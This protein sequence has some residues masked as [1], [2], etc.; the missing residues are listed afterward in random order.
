MSSLN[1]RDCLRKALALAAVGGAGGLSSRL[2]LAGSGSGDARLVVVILRGALD[3]LALLPPVGDADYAAARGDQALSLTAGEHA[4]IPLTGPFA[5]HPAMGFL[6]ERWQAR[7][8]VALHAVASPYRERSHFD[9]QDVLETGYA[10]PHAVQSGWLNRALPAV[11]KAGRR[12]TAVALGPNVPLILRGSS[13]VAAWSPSRLPMLDED[14]L[15][16][17]AELYAPDTLLSGRLADALATEDMVS[18]AMTA[19]ANAGAQL[20]QTVQAA[21]GFLV[22]EDGPRVAVFDTSG[23]DTHANEGAAQGALAQ[24]LGVL[25]QGLRSLCTSLGDVWQHTAVVVVTEFGRTVA[26]NG[27]RGTDHGTGAAALLV[28]GGVQGGRVIA[29]W[30]GLSAKALYAGRDLQPTLD[31]RSVFKSLLRDHLGVPKAH[32]ESQVFPDSAAA[33]YLPDLVRA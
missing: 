13:A 27:T 10:R 28:G 30:P 6:A 12:E 21:A 16:R 33:A 32:I 7:Q 20:Q 25:D 11:A 2:A 19:G 9:G 5:L 14:T 26:I 29:D 24:R 31:L 23:W 1:R 15:Q 4:A 18:S 22:R 8:L 3:G 17:L